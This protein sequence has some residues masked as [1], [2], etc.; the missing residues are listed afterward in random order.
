[1]AGQEH[2]GWLRQSQPVMPAP[3]GRSP[4]RCCRAGRTGKKWPA[5]QGCHDGWGLRSLEKQSPGRL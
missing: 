5:Q 3:C 1:M 4:A 2:D